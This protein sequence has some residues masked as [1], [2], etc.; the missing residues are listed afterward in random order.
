M[1]ESKSEPE[2]AV[3]QED[4]W[5]TEWV[6]NHPDYASAAKFLHDAE[7]ELRKV[8]WDK[9]AK[10]F[11]DDKARTTRGVLKAREYLHQTEMKL[12]EQYETKAW[13]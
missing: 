7:I 5:E 1:G 9:D 3:E 13:T 2:F 11:R 12:R 8:M 6:K 10:Q 4:A